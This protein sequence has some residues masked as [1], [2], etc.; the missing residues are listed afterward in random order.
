M[1]I[2]RVAGQDVSLPILYRQASAFFAVFPAPIGGLQ[3]LLPEPLEVAPVVPGF[4]AIGFGA[5]D[6]V[7]TSIGPYREMAVIVPSRYHPSWRAPLVPLLLEQRLPDFAMWVHRLPVSTE[8]A[9][10]AGIELWG[11][12]KFLADMEVKTS[13]RDWHASLAAEGQ[14]IF[15]LTARAPERP[16]PMRGAVHTWSRKGDELLRTSI[17]YD[18]VGREQLGGRAEVRFG[19]HPFG[20][21]L[22]AL[23]VRTRRPIQ[24][25]AFSSWR[26]VLPEAQIRYRLETAEDRTVPAAVA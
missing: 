20:R 18:N 12:P 25:R 1:S 16:H 15:E 23:G 26:S 13:G 3:A 2:H 22:A 6:Y 9:L 17:A 10:R 19:D 5:F 24:L 7:H 4:G 14:D 11:Y 8:V 21:E